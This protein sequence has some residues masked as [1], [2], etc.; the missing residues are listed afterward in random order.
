MV[1]L[2]G[3][4][5]R[6]LG[7]P[8]IKGVDFYSNLEV[9]YWLHESRRDLPCCRARR[10]QEKHPRHLLAALAGA[11]EPDRDLDREVRGY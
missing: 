11:A 3:S 10:T 9:I 1:D 2:P 7:L 6:A 5:F 4:K 8:A